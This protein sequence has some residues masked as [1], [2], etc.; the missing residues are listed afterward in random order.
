MNVDYEIRAFEF[1]SLYTGIVH[2]ICSICI[3]SESA[4]NAKMI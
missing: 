2:S 1:M 3:S 4:N